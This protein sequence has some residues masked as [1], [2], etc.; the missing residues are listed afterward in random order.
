MSAA[1]AYGIDLGSQ[2]LLDLGLCH[3]AGAACLR[4]VGEHCAVIPPVSISGT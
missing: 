4:E 2:V 1:L 3:A